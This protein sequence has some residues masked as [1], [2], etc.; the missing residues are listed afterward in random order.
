MLNYCQERQEKQEMLEQIRFCL[1]LDT[2][3][4]SSV[5]IGESFQ[6][7]TVKIGVSV[8]RINLSDDP[9]YNLEVLL[10]YQDGTKKLPLR[11]KFWH[12]VRGYL[13]IMSPKFLLNYSNHLSSGLVWYSNGWFVSSCQVVRYW[14]GGLITGL[15]KPSGIWMVCQ[16]MWLYHLNTVHPYCPVFIRIHYSGVRYSDGYCRHTIYAMVDCIAFM[17]SLSLV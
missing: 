2:L 10:K 16:V 6:P 9:T 4:P 13:L 12:L 1:S 8:C 17:V 14:N 3:N 11:G 5:S 7:F 15:R